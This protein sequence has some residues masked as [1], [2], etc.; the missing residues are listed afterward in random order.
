MRGELSRSVKLASMEK[1]NHEGEGGD[2]SRDAP[3]PRS[4]GRPGDQDQGG[5]SGSRSQGQAEDVAASPATP[6]G[7]FLPITHPSLSSPPSPASCGVC[8]SP[9]LP[10]SVEL[11]SVLA[12]TRLTL[13]VYRGGAAALPLLWASL[14]GQLL[15]VQY[16]TVGSE[17]REG[18]DGALDVI[19]NLTD[20]HTLTIRGTVMN[21]NVHAAKPRQRCRFAQIPVVLLLHTIEYRDSR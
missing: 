19:P 4:P 9:P 7:P 21:T 2:V 3:A 12:D 5:S 17:D 20:L 14:P 1:S 13:D 11:T 16:L 18:L 10:P 8:L 6:R 15:G